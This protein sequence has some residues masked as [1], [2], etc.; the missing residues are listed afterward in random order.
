M[1]FERSNRTKGRVATLL[2]LVAALCAAA[3]LAR[4]AGLI[5]TD[6]DAETLLADAARC[7]VDPND[8]H[9]Y[10]AESG[11]IAEN[12]K[13]KNFFVPP[14]QK[15]HPVKAVAGILGD[16]ALINGKWYKTGAKLD[17]AEIL[18]IEPTRVNIKWEGQEKWFAPMG[19]PST[20]QPPQ[21]P[22][23][24]AVAAPQPAELAPKPAKQPQ[25]V[26]AKAPKP[27]KQE[28]PFGWLGVNL[29]DSLKAKLLE[30]WNRLDETQQQRMKDQWLAMSDEQKQQA[31]SMMEQHL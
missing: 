3:A 24:P 14:V 7:G 22:A 30:Q 28:D 18:A 12:L 17:D 15:Q 13:K 16:E 9:Q 6:A 1:D 11:K 8:L 26:E 23:K 27:Q 20:P 4:V 29:S 10:L 5:S 2:L 19:A 31:V 25:P 21:P